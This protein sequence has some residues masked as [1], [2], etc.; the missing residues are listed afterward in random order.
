MTRPGAG[1]QLA[2]AGG[3]MTRFDRFWEP[4]AVLVVT[5]VLWIGTL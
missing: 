2:L 1:R 3:G 4:L 5:A